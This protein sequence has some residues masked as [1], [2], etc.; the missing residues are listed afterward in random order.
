M[1]LVSVSNFL[2]LFFKIRMY[3]NI[4]LLKD[5]LIQLRHFIQ[6]SCISEAVLAKEGFYFLFHFSS[7]L[8]LLEAFQE[9]GLLLRSCQACC[10]LQNHSD[11]RALQKGFILVFI[12]WQIVAC[13]RAYPQCLCFYC[14]FFGVV[15][16]PFIMFVT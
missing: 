1:I 8:A 11:V 7:R 5:M 3:L 16:V 13:K 4:K 15:A 2:S 6:C 12:F 14:R 10:L 9:Q